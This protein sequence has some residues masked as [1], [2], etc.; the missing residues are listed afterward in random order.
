M[1]QNRH[2]LTEKFYMMDWTTFFKSSSKLMYREEQ[3]RRER[4]EPGDMWGAVF[5]TSHLR[6]LFSTTLRLWTVQWQ[7]LIS[8]QYGRCTPD[9]L[10]QPLNIIC[11]QDIQQQH[12][13][14]CANSIV[15]LLGRSMHMNKDIRVQTMIYL[16]NH[17]ENYHSVQTN[18]ITTTTP[19]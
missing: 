6:P 19:K 17:W 14:C 11:D 5:V 4:A 10:Y 13:T 18:T 8:G 12:I 16:A 9:T 3:E 1:Y 7:N 2:I 15:I